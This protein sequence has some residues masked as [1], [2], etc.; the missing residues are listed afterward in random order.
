VAVKQSKSVTTELEPSRQESNGV[1]VNKVG[2]LQHCSVGKN[3][4]DDGGAHKKGASIKI[5][6]FTNIGYKSLDQQ[7]GSTINFVLC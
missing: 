2:A 6:T 5:T 1:V 3:F 4:E 7:N